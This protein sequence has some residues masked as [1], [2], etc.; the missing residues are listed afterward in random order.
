MKDL[1]REQLQEILE[2]EM[3]QEGTSLKWWKDGLPHADL[4]KA[5][6]TGADLSGVDRAGADL[7]GVGRAYTELEMELA[8]ILTSSLLEQITN[9]ETHSDD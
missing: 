8:K 7:S 1:T 4:S 2:A 3:N 9:K 6:L 5:T